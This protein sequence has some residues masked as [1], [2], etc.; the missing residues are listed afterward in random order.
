MVSRTLCIAQES[1]ADELLSNDDFALLVG[2]MLDQQFPMEHAFRGPWKLAD[3]MGGFDINRIAAA[4][5]EEFEELAA[6]PPAI[7]RYGRS[8]GRRVQELARYIVENYDGNT[9]GLWTEGDPDGKEVLKRLKK[10]PGFGDQKARIFLALLGKQ[11][12]LDAKGWR[13]AAGAYGED[14]S[15]RSVADVTDA[16]SLTQVR[17]FKK[18]AKAAAKAK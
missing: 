6:T 14:G 4:D 9:A 5:P 1:D 3:R 17:E 11:R 18:Q 10:L 12:G 15:R 13:E 8:M 7:H 16:E 2:M